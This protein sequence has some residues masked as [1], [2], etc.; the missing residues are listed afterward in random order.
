MKISE[1]RD[2]ETLSSVS[3]IIIDDAR[4]DKATRVRILSGNTVLLDNDYYGDPNKE[5][6]LDIR[7]IV[8]NHT[9]QPVPGLFADDEG[10]PEMIFAPSPAMDISADDNG[11]PVNPGIRFEEQARLPI[12]IEVTRY[13]NS[14]RNYETIVFLCERF[15]YPHHWQDSDTFD[16]EIDEIQ[17]PENYMLPIS[18]FNLFKGDNGI[19]RINRV[20]VISE[21]GKSV[22]DAI[23]CHGASEYEA[24]MVTQLVRM[25]DIPHD[26]GVPFYVSTTSYTDEASRDDIHAAGGIP[27]TINSPR[28]KVVGKQMEQYA[29][30]SPEGIYYNIPMQGILRNIPEYDMSTLKTASGYQKMTAVLSD[31]HEQNSGPLSRRTA[32]A[33]A[34]YLC[35]DMAYYW[36]ADRQLFRRIV[37]ENPSVSISNS[38]G[39]Y[40]LTFQW[41]YEDNNNYFNY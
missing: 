17:V 8:R 25:K 28:F 4:I 5:I 33:L 15:V 1:L 37:I 19:D 23:M 30:L 26:A 22:Y 14:V 13:Y 29:F 20:E 12:T 6:H 27:H 7:D 38:G 35:A 41:R 21:H 10:E 40:S 18:M 34:K 2:Y 11:S 36:D 39:V 31:L 32:L 9:W 3:D 24:S 16:S